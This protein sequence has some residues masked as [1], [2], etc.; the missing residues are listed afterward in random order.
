MADQWEMCIVGLR[1]ITIYNPRIGEYLS[2]KDFIQR[3]EG[4]LKQPHNTFGDYDPGTTKRL[5]LND[6]WQP[7]AVS[8]TGE[9]FRRKYQ[10]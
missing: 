5:I 4:Q 1:Y 9:Y 7:Y 6:G 3:Y 8:E 2:H 10:G